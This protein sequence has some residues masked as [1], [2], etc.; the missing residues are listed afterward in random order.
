MVLFGRRSSVELSIHHLCCVVVVWGAR[1]DSLSE[2][3]TD[4]KGVIL[5]SHASQIGLCSMCSMANS[6]EG[7]RMA[8]NIEKP[9]KKLNKN[10]NS[11]V[12]RNIKEGLLEC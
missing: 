4:K 10:C 7:R 1:D 5:R 8:S 6:N 11:R 9:R 2:W 3:V 12:I